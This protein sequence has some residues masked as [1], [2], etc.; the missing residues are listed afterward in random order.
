MPD[1]PWLWGLLIVAVAG[2][3]A[4]AIWKGRGIKISKSESGLGIEVEKADAKHS[5]INVGRGIRIESSTVGDIAGVK[6]SDSTLGSSIDVARN[7]KLKDAQVGDIAGVKG[8]CTPCSP[9][10]ESV[11]NK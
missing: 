7:A 9:H 3:V 5:G 4:F 10:D 6:N 1:V 11:D 2:V 8:K